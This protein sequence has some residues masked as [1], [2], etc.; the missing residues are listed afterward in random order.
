MLGRSARRAVYAAIALVVLAGA[1]PAHAAAGK[2]DRGFSGDGRA[3]AF[4]NGA[5]AFG[6]AVD[7]KGRYGTAHER[8]AL[9]AAPLAA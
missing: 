5:T 8:A 1:L 2:L 6:V 9:V 7:A 3:T 4:P